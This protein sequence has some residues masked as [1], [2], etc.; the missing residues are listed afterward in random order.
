M[1]SKPETLDDLLL[2]V[3]LPLNVVEKRAKTSSR[4]LLSL[5]KGEIEKP[6]IGTI[7]K[8]AKALGVE[9]AR[10]MAACQAS[11]ATAEKD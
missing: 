4:A 6:R 1:A 3:G 5:R 10:V 9:P 7:A 11:R 2:A 8:L